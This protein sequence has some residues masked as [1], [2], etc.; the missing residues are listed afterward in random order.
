MKERRE[1]GDLIEA[2]KVLTG[3]YKI[4]RDAWF[5]RS[6]FATT[7]ETRS[8]VTIEDGTT[9]RNTEVLYKPPA[10]H[11]TRNNFFTVRVVRRWNELP[12]EVRSQKSINGF[13][14]ALDRGLEVR[15][16]LN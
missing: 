16:I 11:D 15:N 8:S 14:T 9:K 2:F 13:K 7:R 3:I 6:N 10:S 12:E 5:R 4:D 1:R